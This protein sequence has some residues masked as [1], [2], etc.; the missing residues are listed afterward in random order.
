MKIVEILWP[1]LKFTEIH[2][3]LLEIKWDPWNFK[4]FRGMP[5]GF[6]YKSKEKIKTCHSAPK[7]PKNE[8]PAPK[9]PKMKKSAPKAPQKGGG[10]GCGGLSTV[11]CS[12]VMILMG[13]FCILLE[14]IG[15]YVK[16][17]G[18]NGNYRKLVKFIGNY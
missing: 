6:H 4:D 2:L 3:N 18:I 9:A 16:S 17:L 1:F 12:F 14:I 11:V 15:N 5:K 8:K 13:F 7:A 10:G